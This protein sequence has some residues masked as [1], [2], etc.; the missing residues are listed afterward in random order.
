MITCVIN[1]CSSTERTR[2]DGN[3]ITFFPFPEDDLRKNQWL[4]NCDLASSNKEPLHICELHFERVHFTASKDLKPSAVPTLFGRIKDAPKEQKA[5]NV[6]QA[7]PPKQ[8]KLD[9]H[10]HALVTPPQSPSMQ[11]NI[12]DLFSGNKADM[13]IDHVIAING[14]AK[15]T[16]ITRNSSVKTYRLIIQIDKIRSKPGPKCKKVPPSVKFDNETMKETKVSESRTERKLRP[17]QIRQPC[18]MGSCKL[19]RCLYKSALAFQCDVC[20]KCYSTKKE[21]A[22]SYSCT[23]CSATFPNPQSLYL[24]IRKH[25]MCDICLTECSSQMAYDKH[26]R[27]HVSTD[28]K[29]PYK[30][31]QCL[32]T[33]EVKDGVKQ[34]CLLEHPKIT[35]QNTVLQVS[36]PSVTAIV[37]QKSDYFCINC[38]IS[39]TSDQAYRNHINSHGKKEGFTCN[40]ASEGNNIIPVPNPLTGSQ[41][42]FLQAV[43][44]SCRVCSK[45]FDNV[46]EVDLHT[47]THLEVPEEDLKCNICKKLFKSSAAFQEHLKHHLSLAHPCPICSKAFINKTTLNIHLKTHPVSSKTHPVSSQ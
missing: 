9:E 11:D 23:K 41:I 45:E 13:S 40:I 14:S 44:F 2:I 29:C 37:P 25:F 22:K 20:G 10:S 6:S 15:S 38:N 3:T 12:E 31:H 16:S 42:G 32:K 8:R 21:D 24:H 19:K 34:H 35:L 26:I 7:T 4:R 1:S 17:L 33:F 36:P 46:G 18:A 43:K 39:F 30:C 47:R 27:L 5:E 28:P